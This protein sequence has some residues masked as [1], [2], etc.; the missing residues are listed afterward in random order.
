M[1]T[2]IFTLESCL[3]I[4]ALGFIF[5]EKKSYLRDAWNIL[6]FII[7]ISGLI[8]LTT[9]S[10]IGF[11][12]VLRILRVLRPLRLITRVKGLKLVISTLFKA[13]P[14]IFNLQLVVIF[15]MYT[16]GILLTTLYSGT[17]RFCVLDYSP[18]SNA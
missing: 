2:V 10:E 11:F 16:F 17:S 7:V 1:N 6:D 12:K 15:F 9:D 14:R 13:L 18:L 4:I 5:N 3:K 8:T